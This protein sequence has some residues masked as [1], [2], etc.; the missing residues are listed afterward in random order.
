M[1]VPENVEDILRQVVGGQA[2]DYLEVHYEASRSSRI[3]YRGRD[4][5]DIGRTADEGGNVRALVEGGWGFASFN[6]LDQLKAKV[7]LAVEEARAVG[8]R[9]EEKSHLAPVAPSEDRVSAVFKKDPLAVSLSD[10]KKLLDEYVETMWA[11]APKIQTSRLSY[12]DS[13]RRLRFANSEGGYIDQERAGV[14]IAAVA[15]AREGSNVQQAYKSFSSTDDYGV[16]EGLHEAIDQVARRAIALA[17]APPV[18]G[19]EYPVVLDPVL[20]GVFAH[21]AFG[22]LSEADFVY[23]NEPMRKVMVLGRRFGGEHLNI[24]DGAAW[25]GLRGS[26]R[27]DDEG[28]PS[29]RTPLIE[30]GVLVS[31]LHS[32]ETAA[33]M[34]EQPTGNARAINYRH[35]PI[36]RMTNTYIE[37]GTWPLDDML[38]GIK[39]GVYCKDAFGGQTSM[40]MFVFS[41]GEAYMIRNGKLAELLRGVALSGNVFETLENIDAIGNDFTW[42]HSGGNCGKG[43]QMPLPVGLGSPHIRIKKCVVGGQ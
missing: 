35:P 27:Y 20:A 34:G 9:S 18:E 36:V 14:L 37:Q 25:P 7:A 28:T 30:K 10:K 11:H 3:S 42:N 24:S 33:K 29:Q 43:E 19:G 23:E 39:E 38:A 8:P 32:R 12:A 22:H 2:A 16:V 15:I 21:E 5:E 41:A 40:E 6:R 1:T 26:Y 31:R 4:L 17:A 13:R